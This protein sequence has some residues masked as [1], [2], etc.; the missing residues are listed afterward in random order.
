MRPATG[1]KTSPLP[2]PDGPF[3]LLSSCA[4]RVVAEQLQVSEEAVEERL[5]QLA[6]LMPTLQQKLTGMKPT[7]LAALAANVPAVAAAMLDLKDIFPDAD[8]SKLAVRQP[9]LVLGFDMA[10]LRGIAEELRELLPRLNVDRWGWDPW[11]AGQGGAECGGEK[12]GLAGFNAGGRGLAT[13]APAPAPAQG[14][15]GVP[16]VGCGGVDL[17][18]RTSFVFTCPD[19]CSRLCSNVTCPGM[20]SKLA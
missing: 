8:V 14:A 20:C 17:A 10:R 15:S 2:I 9:A 12:A 13:P 1:K 16:A 19:M 6:L 5:R 11:A 7:L 3:I 4:Q 18:G